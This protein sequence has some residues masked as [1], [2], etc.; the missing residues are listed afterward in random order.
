MFSISSQWSLSRHLIIFAVL[1]INGSAFFGSN[2]HAKTR[3]LFQMQ[4]H[5]DSNVNPRSDRELTYDSLHKSTGNIL[6]VSSVLLLSQM[7]TSIA[8]LKANAAGYQAAPSAFASSDFL[9]TAPL[10][11]Q[12]ALL[13]SLPIQDELVAELQAYLESFV[14][15]I[16]PSDAQENQIERNDSILWTNLRINAQRAAGMFIYNKN[17]L[18]PDNNTNFN[19]ETAE[20]Q[21]LRRG[22][23]EEYLVQMQQDVLRLVNGSRKSSVSESLRYM[24]RSLNGLCSVAYML[25]PLNRAAAVL[26][27]TVD[28]DAEVQK[29][30]QKERRE[31]MKQEAKKRKKAAGNLL[32]SSSD[33]TNY[34]NIPRLDGR[35]TVVL[36]FQK[37]GPTPSGA[38]DRAQVTI[39]VDGINHPLTGGNF[40]DLCLR[41][42]YNNEPIRFDPFEYDHDVVN[43][44]VFGFDKRGYL[45]EKTGKKREVPLEVLRDA[46]DK[47]TVRKPKGKTDPNPKV[48]DGSAK[49]LEN[50]DEKVCIISS[51]SNTRFT[52]VGLARNSPVFT[53]SSPVLSFAT[54]GAIGMMHDIGDENGASQ[55][56]FWVQVRYSI[57]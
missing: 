17:E 29:E 3:F 47:N 1:C 35:A 21:R 30:E 46:R 54:N 33:P 50:M 57:V 41:G 37:A 14:Q 34:S 25:Y 28:V 38:S 24:R 40:V 13:N 23:S 10:L 55:G 39:V 22:L 11:P 32:D 20:L 8:P 49:I 5:S 19:T 15:L 27:S 36:T 18:L 53:K 43:R 12:S 44:T 51:D 2:R 7:S 56:F 9:Y 48:T 26:Q 31:E 45:E 6:K 4:A 52:A 16:N 42:Q